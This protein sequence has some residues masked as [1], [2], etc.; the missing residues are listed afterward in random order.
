MP[1]RFKQTIPIGKP[2][3]NVEEAVDRLIEE[4]PLKEKMKIAKMETSELTSLHMIL[5]PHIRD[6]FELLKAIDGFKTVHEL[7]EEFENLTLHETKKFLS[8]YFSEGY[9]LEK[10]ELFPQIINISEETRQALPLER[11]AL[12]YSLENICDGEYS[13]TEISKKIDVPVKEIKQVLT[14]LDKHVT[15]KKKYIK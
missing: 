8:Y 15:Y 1:D 7:S 6:E 14:R 11:L 4:L 3:E 12:S 9:Y 5:G 10:V 13:I 2:P